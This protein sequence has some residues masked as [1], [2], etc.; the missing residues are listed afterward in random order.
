M[1][2][3]VPSNGGTSDLA[4]LSLRRLD[5]IVAGCTP[6]LTRSGSN[7]CFRP[8]SSQ[9]ASLVSCKGVVL[10]DRILTVH[11]VDMGSLGGHWNGDTGRARR[12]SYDSRLPA[13]SN[14]KTQVLQELSGSPL[15]ETALLCVTWPR[16]AVI[17]LV[18]EVII[19]SFV[20]LYRCIKWCDVSGGFVFG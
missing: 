8:T 13:T 12:F 6:C 7:S 17:L 18:S 16:R 19:P 2:Q 20:Y 14:E 4:G 11:A 5:Q 15:N 3:V 9:A 1:Q 10:A